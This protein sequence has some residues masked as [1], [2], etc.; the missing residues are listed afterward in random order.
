MSESKWRGQLWLMNKWVWKGKE[1]EQISSFLMTL[2]TLSNDWWCSRALWIEMVF[3]LS[4]THLRIS[5]LTFFYTRYTPFNSHYINHPCFKTY[6]VAA[7]YIFISS[8]QHY[9]FRKAKAI[10]H[11]EWILARCWQEQ[12]MLKTVAINICCS[13]VELIQSIL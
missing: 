8:L 3:F 10:K 12:R 9:F 11:K 4:G 2:W 5:H 6:N 1:R 7:I 13:H